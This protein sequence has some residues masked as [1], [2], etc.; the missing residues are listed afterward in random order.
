MSNNCKI[1]DGVVSSVFQATVLGK[2][3]VAYFQCQTCGFIQTETP[4]WLNESYSSAISF[5]DI[6]LIS[7]N[8]KLSE[9]LSYIINLSFDPNGKFVDYAGGYGMLVRIMRDKGYDFY[10]QDKYCENLFARTFDI[11]DQPQMPNNS[12]E[13]LTAFEVFEHLV[14]P[15]DEI[16]K[17]LCYSNA[18]LFS[19]ELQPQK[20]I[21]DSGD[22]WYI[23]P[24]TGQ[25]IAF[26]TEKS[27]HII[28]D[29]LLLNYYKINNGLHI[30]CKNE[31]NIKWIRKIDA[32]N[33]WRLLYRKIFLKKRTSLLPTDY[34][35]I[36]GR[37]VL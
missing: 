28:A 27:L 2:Y 18:I 14:D 23:A 29:K 3:P 17:M 4:F 7:R 22:W 16:R 9:K 35:K 32:S 12:Y 6:G 15:L 34:N 25:H 21:K 13:L 1:C 30:F 36:I 10:R 33:K 26:Y 5:L 19:T 31:I 11:S 8:Q 20:G 24:E 37:K